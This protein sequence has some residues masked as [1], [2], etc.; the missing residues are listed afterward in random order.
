MP[1]SAD[2][3]QIATRPEEKAIRREVEVV[4]RRLQRLKRD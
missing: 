2:R 1:C 3:S 4:A